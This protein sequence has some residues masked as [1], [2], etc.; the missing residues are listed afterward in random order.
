MR[1]A[2]S[3]LMMVILLLAG[4]LD[5]SAQTAAEL[6]SLQISIWPEYDQPGVLVI[7]RMELASSAALPAEVSL[8]IPTAAVEPHAVAMQDVD[9]SLVTLNYST[10]IEQEWTRVTFTTPVPRVQI[11][12]Y[13]PGLDKQGTQRSFEYRWPGD[14]AI[15]NLAVEVQQPLGAGQMQITPNMGSGQTGQDGLTYFR[16]TVGELQSGT[17]FTLK[18]S[19]QKATD[20]L[21]VTTQPVTSSGPI[22]STTPGRTTFQEVLPWVLGG[23]GMLLIAG[24]GLWY[25]QSGRDTAARPVGRRR[26]TAQPAD[27]GGESDAIYCHQCGRRASAGDVFC[28]TCGTKL[29]H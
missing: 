5:A 9:G 27:G 20:T 17:A 24:G 12:Y 19:Y 3:V 8:R 25:W 23:L 2:L 14:L 22:N 1:M 18:I 26:H 6:Q 21:S 11:E 16:S 7:Y 15:A 4:P 28:R 13:D 10:E 29:R